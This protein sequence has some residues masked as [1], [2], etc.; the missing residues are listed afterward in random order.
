MELLTIEHMDLT[1]NSIEY[2]R[3]LK[4]Q[5]MSDWLGSIYYC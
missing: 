4:M 5:S 3:T 1:F 2:I